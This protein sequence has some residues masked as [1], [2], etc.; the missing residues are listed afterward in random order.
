MQN[1]NFLQNVSGAETKKN[2][3]RV[4]FVTNRIGTLLSNEIIFKILDLGN[5]HQILDP[6]QKSSYEVRTA[7]P[8][9]PVNQ[10]SECA[11]P[12]QR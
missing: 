11:R 10:E 9:G 8:R 2:I 5:P 1:I 7:R 4:F 12:N 3:T 6:H